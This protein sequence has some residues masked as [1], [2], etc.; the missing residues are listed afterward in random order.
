V[1]DEIANRLESGKDVP[2]GDIIDL[3]DFLKLFADKCHHG[4]EEGFYF[5]ALEEAGIQ[6]Q[7]GPIGMMLAEHETGRE[8]I[9]GM[10]AAMTEN[11]I[12]K[13]EFVQ[14]A[15][16]YTA[17]LRAH[18]EKENTI[19]FPIGDMK[20]SPS[21]Q[22]ELI[23]LFEEFEEKVIGRGKHEELHKQLKEFNIKYL[24]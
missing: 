10:Q 19:L 13:N 16:G 22:S 6:K 17:L 23:K 14:S 15:R 1:L 18:I 9:R 8:F 20:L 3:I 2:P 24:K 4:K 7:N 5:P 21:K 11:S 12:N